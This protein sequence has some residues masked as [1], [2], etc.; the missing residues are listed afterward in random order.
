MRVVPNVPAIRRSFDYLVPEQF[1]GQV[2]IGTIVR[3]D[4]HGRRVRGWVTELDVSP[5][6]GVAL[7]PIA[8]VT[9]WGPPADVV[10]LA[11]WAAWRWAGHPSALLGTASPPTA[12][13]GLPPPRSART[14]PPTAADPLADHAL[15]RGRAVV[16]LPP[17][18]DP[19]PYVL[20]AARRGNALVVCPSI[21]RAR[22]VAARLGRA[23]APVALM[24]H[25]WARAAA[26]ATVVGARAAAW[27]PVPDLA[28]VVVI[29][30]HDEA[31]QEERTPTWH[32][33][34][35]AIERAARAGVPAVLLSPCPT[36]EALN[37]GDRLTVSTTDERSGWPPVD[38][39]DRRDDDPRRAGLY[40][41][42]LV[43]RLRERTDGRV[44]FVLNRKG[45]SRL[46][47]CVACGNLARCERCGSAV[48][49]PEAGRL[50]CTRCGRARPQVCLVCG[51]IAMKNLRVGVSRIREELEALVNEPV[52]EVTG[53]QPP[54]SNA[55]RVLVGTEAV[56]HQ[57]DNAHMVAFLDFDQELLAP[58]YRAA[59][60]AL[61]LLARAARLVGGRRPGA[62]LIVQ[63][64][65]PQHPVVQSALHADPDRLVL[66]E[67][68]RR[69]ALAYPP[70]AALASVSGPA[71]EAF[72]AAVGAPLGVE[73]L[74]PADGRWLLRAPDHATLGNALA[75]TD[76]PPGRLRLEVD[77]LR[78]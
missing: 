30:E 9:G 8:K 25:D 51:A 32:A 52:G 29:D 58:R 14:P 3:I 15:A 74:G 45:R 75:A 2:R 23:G 6:A 36:L 38:V 66:D 22:R 12:V 26:G 57:L 71:A 61:A 72:I 54:A 31:H 53:G 49:L 41:E 4:V 69:Q 28:A 65:L 60:Q 59:E 43:A 63:T 19:F 73:V 21:G 62:R 70:Y 40:S 10:D 68:P 55:P 37:W 67:R 16:R 35:V 18:A 7:K 50:L 39:V 46:L 42:R 33:R 56:L 1:R 44:V 17:A 77:P 27:A 47:A 5:P 24:P 64:R 13:R 78:V 76:R 34:D 20:A 48:T 11:R